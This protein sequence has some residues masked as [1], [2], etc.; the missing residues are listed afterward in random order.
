L[1]ECIIVDPYG[2]FWRKARDAAINSFPTCFGDF[3]E[4]MNDEERKN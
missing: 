1:E 3:I 4:D 2:G